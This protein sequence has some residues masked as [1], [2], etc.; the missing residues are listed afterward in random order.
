MHAPNPEREGGCKLLR[1]FWSLPNCLQLSGVSRV[2]GLHRRHQ[3]RN[4]REPSRDRNARV[5]NVLLSPF[6]TA[7]AARC[8]RLFDSPLLFGGLHSLGRLCCR[9]PQASM[10]AVSAVSA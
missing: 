5:E 1:S 6:C 10:L 4:K 3:R 9:L 7:A 8:S 2:L